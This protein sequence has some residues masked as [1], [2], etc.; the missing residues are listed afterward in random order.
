MTDNQETSLTNNEVTEEVVQYVDQ[1]TLELLKNAKRDNK[2]V[3]IVS[4]F[5]LL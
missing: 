4:D 3:I 5:Y 1:E 2:K